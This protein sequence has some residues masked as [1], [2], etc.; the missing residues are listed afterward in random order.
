[1]KKITIA[2]ALMAAVCCYAENLIKNSDFQEVGKKGKLTGWSYKTGTY[3]PVKSEDAADEGKQGVSAQV[4]APEEGSEKTRAA[5]YM[6]QKIQL[7]EAGKLQLTLVGK[8]DGTGAISCS[9]KFFD[10]S[11]TKLSVKNTRSKSIKGGKDD[12]WQTVEQVVEV[13]EGA[14]S[15]T[16]TII[17]SANK[18]KQESGTMYIKQVSLTPVEE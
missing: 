4:T 13:P 7:P 6:S 14:K 18:K 12:G 2:L 10:E 15:M 5:V 9:W 1:M 17:C 11:G 8:I 16:L 3:S